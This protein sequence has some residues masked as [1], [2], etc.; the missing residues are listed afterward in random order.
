MTRR[1][2]EANKRRAAGPLN[3]PL[4]EAY[5]RMYAR[6]T[7][8]LDEATDLYEKMAP[9]QAARALVNALE[10]ERLIHVPYGKVRMI[11]PKSR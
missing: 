2:N 3:E 4:M 1:R 7:K 11:A 6:L 10:T 8:E 5:E 9:S